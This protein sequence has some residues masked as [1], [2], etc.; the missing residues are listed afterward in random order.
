MGQFS[1]SLRMLGLL[2]QVGLTMVLSV[3]MSTG[4]G[5]YLDRWLETNPVGILSGVVV[6]VLAGFLGSYRLLMRG[7]ADGKAEERS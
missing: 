4:A 2:P 7:L 6:G 5:V 3:L 1:E